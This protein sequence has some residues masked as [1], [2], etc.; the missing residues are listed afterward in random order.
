MSIY[1]AHILWHPDTTE[2]ERMAKFEIHTRTANLY[3]ICQ[4]K[5]WLRQETELLWPRGW[6]PLD[7][8]GE[9]HAESAD[10]NDWYR[11]WLEK[12]V[13]SQGWA[14]DWRIGYISDISE[15]PCND[16]LVIKFRD[17]KMATMFIL[18][19]SNHLA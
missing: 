16:T 13:G 7:E 9:V 1:G 2:I 5:Y 6:A 10:P 18:K 4:W 14:W 11:W 12:Y 8:S 17:P 3:R 19:W 15:V